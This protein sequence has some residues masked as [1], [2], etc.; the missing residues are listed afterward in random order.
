MKSIKYIL[1]FILLLG[2]FCS[3]AQPAAFYWSR[4]NDLIS[5]SYTTSSVNT[6]NNNSV[7]VCNGKFGLDSNYEE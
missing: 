4:T 2:S 1:S 6:P 7:T 5:V 3:G